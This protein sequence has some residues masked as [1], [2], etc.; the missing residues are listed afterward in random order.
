MAKRGD[1]SANDEVLEK[2]GGPYLKPWML[3]V[4]RWLLRPE[5]MMD[6]RRKMTEESQSIVMPKA[7]WMSTNGQIKSSK[8]ARRHSCLMK[9]G[10]N[11]HKWCDQS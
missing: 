2:V 5:G 1:A 9:L 8:F 7:N 11:S 6:S 10:S 4:C 3:A